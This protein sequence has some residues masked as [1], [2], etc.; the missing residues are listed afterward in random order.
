MGFRLQRVSKSKPCVRNVCMLASYRQ[1]LVT[2]AL[3]NRFFSLF[4][5][6]VDRRLSEFKYVAQDW[7]QE[8]MRP[9]LDFTLLL[10]QSLWL[11][12]LPYDCEPTFPWVLSERYPVGGQ[13]AWCSMCGSSVDSPINTL[14]RFPLSSPH[15]RPTDERWELGGLSYGAE[16]VEF[17]KEGRGQARLRGPRAQILCNRHELHPQASLSDTIWRSKTKKVPNQLTSIG[18]LKKQ[19]SLQEANN[20]VAI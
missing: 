10:L 19:V 7:V 20:D 13:H 4:G 17:T 2:E 14:S 6:M 18:C 8:V 15:A 1:Q 11:W 12:R 5:G 9:G 3:H 16:L